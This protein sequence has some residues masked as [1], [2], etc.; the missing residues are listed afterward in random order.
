MPVR[1]PFLALAALTAA[2]CVGCASLKEQPEGAAG[3]SLQGNWTLDDNGHEAAIAQLDTLLDKQRQKLRRERRRGPAGSNDAPGFEG[4]PED[5]SFTPQ[6]QRERRDQLVQF[7][8]PPQQLAIQQSDT[9]V[10]LKAD[11]ASPRDLEPGHTLTRFDES[12]TA[13]IEAGWDGVSFVVRTRFTDGSSREERYTPDA[14]AG[15]LVVVRN[16]DENSLGKVQLTSRYTRA[17]P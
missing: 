13:T 14:K 11:N 8:T 4:G 10:L 1:T 6:E 5:L 9:D 15:S 12:G 7:L 2:L 3:H 16:L 17:A